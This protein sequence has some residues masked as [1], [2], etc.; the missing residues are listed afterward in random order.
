M[1]SVVDAG[2]VRL[3]HRDEVG[4]CGMID[5]PHRV[6]AT[7]RVGVHTLTDTA[8]FGSPS[9]ACFHTQGIGGL[10]VEIIAAGKEST[11]YHM[12]VGLKAY[13]EVITDIVVHMHAAPAVVLHITPAGV[14]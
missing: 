12:G 11:S 9:C 7:C 8:T 10:V 13:A 14:P 3:A 6:L 1:D 2:P 5:A 4:R